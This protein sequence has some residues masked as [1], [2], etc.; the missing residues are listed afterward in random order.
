M[1]FPAS[2]ELDSVDPATPPRGWVERMMPFVLIGGGFLSLAWSCL[3][4]WTLVD[5]IF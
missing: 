5:L 4:A 1:L 2:T 3:L